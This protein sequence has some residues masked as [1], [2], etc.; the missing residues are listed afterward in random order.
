ME[1]LAGFDT[2]ISR[3]ALVDPRIR[4]AALEDPSHPF[5]KGGNSS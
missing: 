3:L 2:V 5:K 1:G 4:L